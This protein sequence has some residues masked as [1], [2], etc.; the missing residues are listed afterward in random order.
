MGWNSVIQSLVLIGVI[1][2][3]VIF[4]LYMILVRTVEGARHRHDRGAESARR[5][6]SELNLKIK[7]ADAALARVLDQ[8][9]D[10]AAKESMK[11]PLSAE[12]LEKLKAEAAAALK[13]KI[14]SRDA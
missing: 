7:E 3:A 10:T 13:Q 9:L 4:A 8:A 1:A 5:K 11:G 12:F 14:G 2:G 6:E